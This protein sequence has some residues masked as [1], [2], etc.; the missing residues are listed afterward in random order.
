[1]FYLIAH[2][3]IAALRILIENLQK[4]NPNSEDSQDLGE[5]PSLDE[6]IDENYGENEEYDNDNM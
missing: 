3:K 5:N 4:P 2:R 1:M 6:E